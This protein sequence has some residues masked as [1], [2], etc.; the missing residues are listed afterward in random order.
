MRYLRIA[1]AT[2][3]AIIAF[4]FAILARLISKGRDCTAEELATELQALADGRDN[5][6]DC[7]RLECVPIKNSRLEEIRREAALLIQPMRP[8]NR[9]KLGRLVARARTLK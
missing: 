9:P 6:V 3:L 1:G 7:D 5:S 8:E 4:P 2:L